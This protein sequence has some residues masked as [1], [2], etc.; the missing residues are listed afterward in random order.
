MLKKQYNTLV[1]IFAFILC[2]Q[3]FALPVESSLAGSA[4]VARNDKTLTITQS[5]QVGVGFWDSFNIDAGETVRIVQPSGG[6]YIA[7]IGSQ[8][9][10]Q[11]RGT[12]N[13][14]SMVILEN[15]A[16]LHLGA[17][18]VV[19]VGALIA[20]AGR[21]DE[22]SQG[23]GRLSISVSEGFITN[24]GAITTQSRAI[25]ISKSIDN[26]GTI[27][28][29]K[30]DID[31]YSGEKIM[32][33]FTESGISIEVSKKKLNALISNGGTLTAEKGRIN[34]LPHDMTDLRASVVNLGGMVSATKITID[35]ASGKISVSATA[36]GNLTI[37]GDY[38]EITGDADITTQKLSIGTA[39]KPA[40]QIL[41]E[42]GA[43]FKGK[44]DGALLNFNFTDALWFSGSIN[45]AD[46][47]VLINKAAQSLDDKRVFPMFMG[48]Y[49]S[50]Y[51]DLSF[52]NIGTGTLDVYS[53]IDLNLLGS[54]LTTQHAS[55]NAINFFN[56]NSLTA[57][58]FFSLSAED[59]NVYSF[60]ADIDVHIYSDSYIFIHGDIDTASKEVIF[61]IQTATGSIHF[62]EKQ[63]T[64]IKGNKI[65]FN[66]TRA[67][68]L[69]YD[70][71]IEAESSLRVLV[72]LFS[73][74][75]IKLDA[76]SIELCNYVQARELIIQSTQEATSRHRDISLTATNKISLFSD[77]NAKSGD[78]TIFSDVYEVLSDR[79]VRL[80]G[81]NITL[82]GILF[83]PENFMPPTYQWAT[84]LNLFFPQK[85]PG[86]PIETLD[87]VQFAVPANNL[88]I[89][90]EADDGRAAPA[91]SPITQEPEGNPE[92]P[93]VVTPQV[94]TSQMATPQVAG[95]QSTNSAHLKTATKIA[96]KPGH[97]IILKRNKKVKLKTHECTDV[98][99]GFHTLFC[100]EE[101]EVSQ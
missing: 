71:S 40:K 85:L 44:T 12:L 52:T 90:D 2:E 60:V 97:H 79:S 9:A 81:N 56:I 27:T 74:A 59:T 17:N 21:I 45:A 89:D 76:P 35:K 13:A 82:T 72:N 16:G 48:N 50:G 69:N 84:S 49:P 26:Q 19:N 15:A 54:A 7:R 18:A 3:A 93:R 24:R 94:V 20:I 98:S 46:A 4:Q 34:I 29:A 66:S 88:P 14:D 23:L 41:I 65:E 70:V 95:G 1:F 96:K 8:S 37:L 101:Y 5:Q 31:L 67:I 30:S 75:N 10:T 80:T 92:Q 32:L 36:E 25:F 83:T 78:L 91:Q 38:I 39:R 68:N 86:Q 64:T 77:I 51:F 53:E 87:D 11:I 73:T 47:Y 100:I 28:S 43:E 62:T 58:T 55:K 6:R 63:K 22:T 57:G 61:L 33:T 99:F 42:V